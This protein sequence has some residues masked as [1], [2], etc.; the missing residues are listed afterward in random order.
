MTKRAVLI[1]CF[2]PIWLKKPE[3]VLISKMRFGHPP[4]SLKRRFSRTRSASCWIALMCCRT[5][6][7]MS[8]SICHVLLHLVC[9][10]RPSGP[11]PGRTLF[12][13]FLIQTVS[14]CLRQVGLQRVVLQVQPLQV[15]ET[16][17]NQPQEHANVPQAACVGNPP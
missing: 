15:L 3:F 9:R 12:A 17:P 16:K 4:F 6:E 11:H 7:E 10:S 5:W 1:C 8:I 13:L 2:L 14:C